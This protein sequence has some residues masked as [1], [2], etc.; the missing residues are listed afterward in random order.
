MTFERWAELGRGS[1][2]V[3]VEHLVDPHSQWCFRND[4][5]TTHHL[6]RQR[7]LGVLALLYWDSFSLQLEQA[8]FMTPLVH[9]Q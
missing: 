7:S 8:G 6:V 2:A 5:Y 9:T 1:A 3:D 4:G